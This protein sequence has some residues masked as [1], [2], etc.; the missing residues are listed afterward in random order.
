M[1]ATKAC[2]NCAFW[3]RSQGSINGQCRRFPPHGSVALTPKDFWCGE[4]HPVPPTKKAK[5]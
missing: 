4:W 5:G 3:V 1:S 2:E